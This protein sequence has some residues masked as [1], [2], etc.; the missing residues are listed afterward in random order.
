[1]EY[2]GFRIL[3]CGLKRQS[4]FKETEDRFW[5]CGKED[6]SSKVK[7]QRNSTLNFGL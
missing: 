2:C 3:E 5:G 4:E 7:V 1:M 6:Q